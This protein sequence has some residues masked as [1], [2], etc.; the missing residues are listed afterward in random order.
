MVSSINAFAEYQHKK[1]WVWEHQALTRARFSAGDS[2]VGEQFEAIRKE[3]L[4][5]PRA[6]KELRKEVVEMRQKMHEGHINNTT[7]FDIKHDQGGMVDI[8]FMVQFLVL[9]YAPT[10]PE[11]T[12]NSGNLALLELAAKLGLIDTQLSKLSQEIYR[13]LRRLQHKMRLNNMG[14]CRINKTDINTDAVTKLW[15]VML[16]DI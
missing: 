14:A 11:L 16:K 13:N 10:Y 4:C 5:Q 3:V 15:D 2:R 12:A 8:E 7:L 1:A 6:I 9:A